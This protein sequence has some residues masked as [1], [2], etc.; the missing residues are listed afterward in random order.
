MCNGNKKCEIFQRVVHNSLLHFLHF[1][2]KIWNTHGVFIYKSRENA[3]FTIIIPSADFDV[4]LPGWDPW[5][6]LL[7]LDTLES[8]PIRWYRTF[9]LSFVE[10]HDKIQRYKP[11]LDSGPYYDGGWREELVVRWNVWIFHHKKYFVSC[12]TFIDVHNKRFL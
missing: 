11:E 5:E 4:N 8:K 12:L 7:L 9:L 2:W 6:A 3:N 10:R 1:P